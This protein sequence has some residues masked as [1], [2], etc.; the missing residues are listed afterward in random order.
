MRSDDRGREDNDMCPEP[1]GH[2]C[3]GP[4]IQE[5]FQASEDRDG[6][7]GLTRGVRKE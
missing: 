1:W 2:T 6:L 7:N 3:L 5:T 4:N